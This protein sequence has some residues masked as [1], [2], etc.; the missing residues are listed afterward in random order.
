ML[1]VF[2]S[3]QLHIPL[4]QVRDQVSFKDMILYAGY[5]AQRAES[6][7]ND[8]AAMPSEAIESLFHGG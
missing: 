1:V 5:F 3:L 4:R 8:M 6:Q 2:M 7:S